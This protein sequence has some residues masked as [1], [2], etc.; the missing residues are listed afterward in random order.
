[1]TTRSFRTPR[2]LLR[3]PVAGDLA[4]MVRLNADPEVMR[5]VG[6][7]KPRTPEATRAGLAKLC[8][9]PRLYEGLGG[10]VAQE[11]STGR[12][13]GVFFLV[14]IPKTT[15]VEIGYRLRKSA[16]GKGYA[17]EGAAALLRYGFTELE[18]DRIVAVTYPA[19]QASRKV[20]CK[21]GLED[22][23]MAYYYEKNVCY[24]VA[25]RA[26]FLSKPKAA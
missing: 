5:F 7:G 22:R 10:W 9:M 17:T 14:Y 20:L 4:E 18:L 3:R 24:F 8:D 15:E 19:N 11:R 12:F 13:V 25:E 23:G 21:I 26:R 1:M 16:W 6:D 2:L